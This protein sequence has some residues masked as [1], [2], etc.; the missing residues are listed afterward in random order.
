MPAT[1]LRRIAC[2][3]LGHRLDLAVTDSSTGSRYVTWSCWC[4]SHSRVERG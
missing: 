2:A 3:V 1:T 4:G